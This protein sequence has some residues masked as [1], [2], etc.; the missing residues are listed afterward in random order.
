MEY[1]YTGTYEIKAKFYTQIPIKKYI[2]P[3]NKYIKILVIQKK[4]ITYSRWID[5]AAYEITNHYGTKH[6]RKLIEK[7]FIEYKK[8]GDEY[9]TIIRKEQ[10][11]ETT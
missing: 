11:E 5:I 3:P 8:S 10:L 9:R 2:K 6:Q 1:G 4:S 7:D